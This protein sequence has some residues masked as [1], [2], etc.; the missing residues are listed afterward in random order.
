MSHQRQPD[1]VWTRADLAAVMFL[2]LLGAIWLTWESAQPRI[3]FADQPLAKSQRVRAAT[4]RID[5]NTA[6]AASMRRLG[7]IGPARA[8][9]IIEYR[10]SH[11][12]NAFRTAADLAGVHGIGP[13][14]IHRIAPDLSLPK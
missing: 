6:S 8:G 4:D 7:G 2:L 12:P 1:L 11:G 14:T 13:G 5:P 3:E 9:A 10:S